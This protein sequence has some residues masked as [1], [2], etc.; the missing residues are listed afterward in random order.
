[1]IVTKAGARD[2]YDLL[3]ALGIETPRSQELQGLLYGVAAGPAW[4]VRRAA[5][6]PPLGLFGIMP[7]EAHV[8]WSRM[9]VGVERC[10]PAFVA[11]ARQCMRATMAITGQPV[12]MWVARSNR[13]GHV[14]AAACG[15]KRTGRVVSGQVEIWSTEG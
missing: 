4:V 3:D 2:V 6:A 11:A 9:G 7:G 13:A 5:F 14:M 10:L 8:M 15:L 12:E 1:M